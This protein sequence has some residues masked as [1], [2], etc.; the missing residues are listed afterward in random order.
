MLLL[1]SVELTAGIFLYNTKDLSLLALVATCRT[2]KR[3]LHEEGKGR[4][5]KT[6]TMVMMDETYISLSV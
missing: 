5:G 4:E 1:R 2:T 6:T 3:E